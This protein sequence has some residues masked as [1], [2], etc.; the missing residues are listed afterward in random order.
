MELARSL[1]TRPRVLLTSSSHVY[2][3][4]S[5]ESPRVDES[6]PLGPVFGYGRTKLLAEAEVSPGGA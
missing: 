4:V 1:P 3:P 2:A 5:P 6:A